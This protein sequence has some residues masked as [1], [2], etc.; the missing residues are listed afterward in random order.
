MLRSFCAGDRHGSAADMLLLRPISRRGGGD[1]LVVGGTRV[2]E[3]PKIICQ[4]IHLTV[5]NQTW[6]VRLNLLVC[7]DFNYILD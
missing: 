1:V 5:F 4:V 6:D 3:G 2:E 7:H